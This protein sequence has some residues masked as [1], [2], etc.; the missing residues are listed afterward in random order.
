MKID[1]GL[2]DQVVLQRNK[3]NRSEGC[4][5]G[6]C[7]GSGRVQA[8][9]RSK[10][11][12]LPGWDW[13][14]VGE[15]VRGRFEG[16]LAGLPAGG[17][18]DVELRVQS[19]EGVATAA[20][21][22]RDVL[23]GDVWIL[24]GQSNME[25]IGLI[26]EAAR[27]DPLVR[28]F[29]MHDQWRVARDPIHNLSVAVDPVHSRTARSPHVGVGPGVAFGQEMHRRTGVPQ[30]LIA[31]AH[32]G[33]SM[34]AWDPK[35]KK[36]GGKSLYGAMRRR[37]VKNGSRVAG[38]AWYQGCSDA[39]SAVSHEYFDKMKRFIRCVRRDLRDPH[40]PFVAV[41]IGRVCNR[42]RTDPQH[43]NRVQ[44]MQR[45]LPESVRRCSV[46]PAIDLSMDDG[47]HISGNDQNRLG[48]RIAQAMAQL[49]GVRG[50][51]KPPIRL[52][53]VR[54]EHNRVQEM[55]EVVVEF[56]NV[57]GRLQ[58][59]GRPH[60]FDLGDP[61]PAHRVY[62][63][64]L[65]GNRAI[66]RSALSA[67][68]ARQM[69]LYYGHGFNP[70][71]NIT[72]SA[73]RAVPVL[74]PVP[75]AKPAALTPFVSTV[76]VSR[77]L[78]GRGKLH[79]VR[80]PKETAKLGFTE[81]TFDSDYWDLHVEFGACAPED[82]LVFF[83]FNLDCSEAMKLIARFG[84][85]GPVKLWIDGKERF[86]DPAG[87]NPA[88]PDAQRVP[89][90]VA[91]GRHEVLVGMGANNGLAW[92]CFLRFER[93]DVSPRRVKLGRGYAMPGIDVDK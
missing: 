88:S 10:G 9:V 32:G 57:M 51:G 91:A 2:F 79:D 40:L 19:P 8:R 42:G 3:R 78:P 34:D 56:D 82:R 65:E 17:P 11:K 27:P 73:D 4:F 59:T 80:Y 1:T 55:A 16:R 63:I 54:V 29:Y 26:R 22:V 69:S 5:S 39:G 45:Q 23:V 18:Y 58:S 72:D 61:T 33:T 64:R 31:C 74:G 46:V 90:R 60:G 52:K 48:R 93:Q 89:F 77:L 84:Y 92:G 38:V 47:I 70:Y 44:E 6:R 66:L 76:Q 71:C 13:K 43:W 7:A 50:A 67:T 35:L 83:R 20:A 49:L 12:T 14:R 85:D 24:A 28:A 81:R 87:T 30:G 37:F 36:L 41:Q 86:H 53:R 62:D 21:V 75:V 15:A 68:Q 25:G